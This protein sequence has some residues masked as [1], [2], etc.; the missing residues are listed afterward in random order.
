VPGEHQRQA[1]GTLIEQ[2][3]AWS[4]A[5]APLRAVPQPA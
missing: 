4:A 3:V 1:L 5:L 2:V